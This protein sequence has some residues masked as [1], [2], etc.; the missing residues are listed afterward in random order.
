MK[1]PIMFLSSAT[2]SLVIVIIGLH[3][4]HG[5]YGMDSWYGMFGGYPHI[6]PYMAAAMTGYGSSFI[7]PK[8]MASSMRRS[9]YAP[10][11]FGGYPAIPP[12]YAPFYSAY[13]M[14]FAPPPFPRS[15]QMLPR[16]Y[17]SLTSASRP[18]FIVTRLKDGQ[19]PRDDG[20]P[21]TVIDGISDSDLV[22]EATG[23]KKYIYGFRGNKYYVG[24]PWEIFN[25]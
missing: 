8:S 23:R 3:S 16:G 19:V 4:V 2:A 12:A 21:S 18:Q 25:K 7:P 17:G 11:A 24:K 20:G 22:A 13:G 10:A 1:S 5:Q 6:P 14:G 9:S 15:P